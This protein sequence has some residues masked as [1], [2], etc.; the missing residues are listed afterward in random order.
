MKKWFSIPLAMLL[1]FCGC[2]KDT[3]DAAAH[4]QVFAMDTVMDLTVYGSSSDAADALSAAEGEIHR[5]DALLSR[6]NEN[7]AVS[8]INKS[9]GAPVETDSE[10][11]ALLKTAVHYSDL[12]DGAFSVTVAPIMDAWNFMGSNPR[13]P[14]RAELDELLTHVGDDRILLTDNTV[15]LEKNMAVDLGGIA[16]G[17][18]SDR[19]AA[20][21]EE[22]G[23]H[24]AMVSLGGNV[25][26]RGTKPNG[27]RWRVAV[28]DPNDPGNYL[29]VLSLSDQFAIT[30]GGYQ[31][32]FEQDGVTYYHIID[33]HTGDVAR[34]G[35]L[36]ATV[37]CG[38]GT[39]GD[40]LS[41]ALFVMGYDRAVEFW[42]TSG[43]DFDMI[44][45]DKEG[46]VYL[47]EGLKDLF[48]ASPAEHNYEYIYLTKN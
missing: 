30:S 11:L 36:S 2:G 44:L 14:S 43:L 25:Y 39:M 45:S 27:S 42:K 6:H 32:Y 10:V 19:L 13:V 21:F 38:S 26:V 23:V 35:L 20:L 47:T 15:T 28:E 40:A 3:E 24:S 4:A 46:R 33:P 37:V 9:C 41:T 48:D 22:E 7:S 18:T 17:Y 29:G 16:K 31:R 34:S 8:A 1:L 5:L 12:T